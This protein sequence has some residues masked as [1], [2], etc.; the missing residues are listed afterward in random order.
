MKNLLGVTHKHPQSA[1]AGLQKSLQQEWSF[2]Q[3]VVPNI[4]DAFGAVEQALQDAFIPALFQGLGEGKPGIWVTCI[5][6]K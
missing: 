6:V 3:R 4:G 1:N 5:P 2:V